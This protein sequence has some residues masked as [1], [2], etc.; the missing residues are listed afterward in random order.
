MFKLE[1]SSKYPCGK[2]KQCIQK[3]K[4]LKST[5][6]TPTSNFTSKTKK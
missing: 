6:P 5:T 2:L 1:D 4:P 3:L